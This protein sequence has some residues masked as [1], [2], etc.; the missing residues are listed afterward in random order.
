MCHMFIKTLHINIV[1]HAAT[2]AAVVAGMVH[3]GLAARSGDIPAPS[4]G[5]ILP[6]LARWPNGVDCVCD[7]NIC[8]FYIQYVRLCIIKS[9]TI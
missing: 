5:Q 4:G 1:P 3:H 9:Y 2:L 8:W 6:D 7:P